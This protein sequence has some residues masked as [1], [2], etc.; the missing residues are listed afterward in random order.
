MSYIS[1]YKYQNINAYMESDGDHFIGNCY[2]LGLIDIS[3]MYENPA[4]AAVAF[5]AMV[6]RRIADAQYHGEFSS[7][8]S[9]SKSICPIIRRWIGF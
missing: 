4:E 5:R 7:N 9:Q 2:A 8:D 6:L 3:L 1:V